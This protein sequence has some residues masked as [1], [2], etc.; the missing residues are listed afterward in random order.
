MSEEF[1]TK[2][3]L[4][5]TSNLE[6]YIHFG[7]YRYDNIVLIQQDSSRNKDVVVKL[8][9]GGTMDVYSQRDYSTTPNLNEFTIP[10]NSVYRFTVTSSDTDMT[11]SNCGDIINLQLSGIN[12]S[13]DLTT[14]SFKQMNKL[15]TLHLSQGNYKGTLECLMQFKKL[16]DLDL[17]W[18]TI[19]G[20]T[21]AF[22]GMPELR[23]ICIVN[24][25]NITG[26]F[27]NVA[28]AV[29][30]CTLFRWMN[31]SGVYGDIADLAPLKK[32]TMLDIRGTTLYGDID[33]LNALD[34]LTDVYFQDNG[35]GIIGDISSFPTIPNLKYVH[36]GSSNLT[37]NI[38]VFADKTSMRTIDLLYNTNIYGDISAFTNLTKLEYLN[39]GDTNITGDL[40]SLSNLT[41][42]I[43]LQM[44]NPNITGDLSS[45]GACTNL[46]L[47][48]LDRLVPT[49][50]ITGDISVFQNMQSLYSV[51][52]DN[53]TQ[54]TGSISD[55]KAT[56]PFLRF[57]YHDNTQ[58]TE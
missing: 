18:S 15:S 51:W 14:G 7:A 35:D 4:G 23:S 6:L 45:L 32:T 34:S 47:I 9:D 27:A 52:L 54:V 22:E 58:I 37:G 36:M 11:I 19:Y 21:Y 3:K 57:V 8:S 30:E 26:D 46:A 38:S 17:Y 1:T 16:R 13:M 42:L 33:D 44:R 12:H 25:N 50:L 53:C 31:C 55:L 29:P 20:S 2:R 28:K 43:H 41:K 24:S 10:D 48:D 56:C 5:R 39:M 40:A 49:N